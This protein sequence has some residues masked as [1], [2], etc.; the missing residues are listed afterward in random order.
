MPADV[1]AGLNDS[2]ADAIRELDAAGRLGQ[3]GVE[4]T[5]GTPAEFA[6]FQA[7]EVQRNAD[8]L[9]SANFKPQ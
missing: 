9:N 4:P 2:A 8:L 3:L 5:F 7:A 6:K 1:V